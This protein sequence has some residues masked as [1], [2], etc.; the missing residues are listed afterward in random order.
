[1]TAR[2][3]R[4][5][6]AT[7]HLARFH[8]MMRMLRPLFVWSIRSAVHRS[9]A[10]QQRTLLLKVDQLPFAADEFWPAG[11]VVVV[12]LSIAWLAVAFIARWF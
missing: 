5:R 4:G 8:E 10:W 12:S 1:M 6:V 2:K 3:A 11:G 9:E 7:G